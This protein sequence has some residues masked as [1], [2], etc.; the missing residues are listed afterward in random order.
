[1]ARVQASGAVFRADRGDYSSCSIAKEHPPAICRF[2]PER[3]LRFRRRT[4]G[5]RKARASMDT[6][7]YAR[8]L[9]LYA[10][11]NESRVQSTR[12]REEW[13]E[14]ES[15]VRSELRNRNRLARMHAMHEITA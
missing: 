8:Q 4:S 13:R 15:V 14:R 6:W 1:M 10:E 5:R 9:R 3:V 7:P 2:A 12:L 11:W